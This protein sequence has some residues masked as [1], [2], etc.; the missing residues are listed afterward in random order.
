MPQLQLQVA[1]LLLLMLLVLVSR[2]LLLLLLLLLWRRRRWRQLRR[3][4][5]RS[6]EPVGEV[7]RGGGIHLAGGVGVR[8]NRESVSAESPLVLSES[9]RVRVSECVRRWLLSVSCDS[10]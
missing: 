6:H 10:V 7:S 5:G 3:L 4:E 8:K 1:L 2:R 9:V